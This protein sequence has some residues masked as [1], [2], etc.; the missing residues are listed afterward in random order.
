MRQLKWLGAGVLLAAV[1]TAHAAGN[2]VISQ[3]YGAGGNSGAILQNDFVELLNRSSAPVTLSGWSVQYA[4]A[5]GTG[6]FS[7]NTVV[8]LSGTLQPGQYYLIKLAGGTTGTALP[9]AD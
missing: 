9:T 6:N 2:V 7:Q 8:P 1:C 5:T 3:V 4:S